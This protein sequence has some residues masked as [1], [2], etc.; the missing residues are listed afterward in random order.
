MNCPIEG[1]Y[2]VQKVFRDE[3]PKPDTYLEKTVIPKPKRV[4]MSSLIIAFE[5]E[6]K[7]LQVKQALKSARKEGGDNQTEHT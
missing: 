7:T 1:A 6:Y 5:G 3:R 4:T 2:R